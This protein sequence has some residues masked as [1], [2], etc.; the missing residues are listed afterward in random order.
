MMVRYP[1]QCCECWHCILACP[2]GAITHPHFMT[3]EYVT[4]PEIAVAPQDM[5][6]LIYARRSVRTFQDRPVPEDAVRT[7]LECARH[8]GTGGNVQSEGYVVIQDR[9]YLKALEVLVVAI[10]WN[11]GLKFATSSGLVDKI[12]AY[13]YGPDLIKQFRCYHDIIAH[14]QADRELEGLI[15]RHA[16]LVLVA[17]GLKHNGVA[18]TN[19]AVALRT[20]ELMACTMGL[21]TCWGGFLIGAADMKPGRINRSL[22]LPSNR[23]VHGILMVGYPKYHDNAKLPRKPVDVRWLNTVTSQGG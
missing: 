21:G 17:H 14:R 10:L 1:A 11:G 2:V 16:P 6:N 3:D 4:L 15:F 20:M 12:M 8:A 7:L 9:D 23:R 13:I 18:R 19:C 5:Q 22:G